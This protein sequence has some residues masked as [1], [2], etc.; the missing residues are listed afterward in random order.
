MIERFAYIDFLHVE[1]GISM[2]CHQSGP[3]GLFVTEI[4]GSDRY[5]A[6]PMIQASREPFKNCVRIKVLLLR[7]N[8]TSLRNPAGQCMQIYV[9]QFGR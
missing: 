5:Q 6:T 3:F 7:A 8:R 4:T 1:H 9:L 2:R